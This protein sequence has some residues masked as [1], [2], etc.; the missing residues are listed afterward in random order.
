MAAVIK[1]QQ[2]WKDRIQPG[3]QYPIDEALGLVKEFANAK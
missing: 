1:R 3:H 2:P